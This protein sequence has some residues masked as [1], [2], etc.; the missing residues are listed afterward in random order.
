M[1]LCKRMDMPSFLVD[2]ED[3][4]N[5]HAYNQIQR[6]RNVLSEKCAVI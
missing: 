3:T 2:Y 4:S 1:N 5:A 6:D